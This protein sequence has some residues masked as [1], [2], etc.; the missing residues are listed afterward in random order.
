MNE[1]KTDSRAPEADRSGASLR[2]VRGQNVLSRLGRLLGIHPIPADVAEELSA[3][4]TEVSTLAQAHL[5]HQYREAAL[6]EAIE[7]LEKQIA[8][9]GK[10]QFKANSLAEAQQQS[11]KSTLEQLREAN[12][13]RERELVSLRERLV[14]A[15]GEG[16]RQVVERLLPVLDGIDEALSAG[17]RMF[18]EAPA[19]TNRPLG[20]P[21]SLSLRRRLRGAGALLAGKLPTDLQSAVLPAPSN[22]EAIAAWWKGLSLV[23]DRLLDILVAE[24][25]H[26]METDG[27][28]FDP[29]VHVAIATTPASDD[30]PAGSIVQE[31]RRGYRMGDAVL[32]YAEV[33]VAR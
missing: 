28:M 8:R 14:N 9:A 33:V 23:R 11:V 13:Y 26:P 4:R 2:P 31:T 5:D 20:A 25:V 6:R 1:Q 32:R 3:L 29:N 21:G 12:T 17:K 27:E 16:R 18:L 24:G 22:S 19:E 10:E 15:R 7:K 30:M